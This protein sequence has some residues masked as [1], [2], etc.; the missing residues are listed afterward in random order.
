MKK[1]SKKK[2][3]RGNAEYKKKTVK[4]KLSDI[5]PSTK[6]ECHMLDLSM[7]DIFDELNWFIETLIGKISKKSIDYQNK[8][9][10]EYFENIINEF[11][12][13][14]KFIES[15]KEN[16]KIIKYL[17]KDIKKIFKN[18][19]IFLAL[20]EIEKKKLNVSLHEL[21]R[22]QPNNICNMDSN[23]HGVYDKLNISFD[24]HNLEKEEG[25]VI[26]KPIFSRKTHIDS[27]GKRTMTLDPPE[28]LEFFK[29]S[30]Y[31]FV[32]KMKRY[33]SKI[34]DKNKNTYIVNDMD[35]LKYL[36]NG[37]IFEIFDKFENEFLKYTSNHIHSEEELHFDFFDIIFKISSE[38][39]EYH[40]DKLLEEND[41][42][43][44]FS[45]KKIN[46]TFLNFIRKCINEK[47]EFV[48]SRLIEHWKD[49]VEK[50]N[51]LKYDKRRLRKN[52][53]KSYLTKYLNQNNFI[54]PFEKKDFYKKG[55]P[56]EKKDKNGDIV[57][58]EN[59]DKI[60]VY[61]WKL[62]DFKFK[63]INREVLNDAKIEIERL[64]NKVESESNEIELNKILE[65]PNIN[66]INRL[67][68]EIKRTFGIENEATGKLLRE[69]LKDLI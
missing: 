18:I 45:N 30:F 7:E 41:S 22:N 21:F 55:D 17:K 10:I 8:D 6:E 16:Q 27:W 56:V 43:N 44:K 35:I 29:P 12:E 1:N 14:D 3:H 62:R 42:S 49:I 67:C 39:E 25:K 47:G 13:S 68:S 46:R 20:K 24:I 65:Q 58:D 52:K 51:K 33:D 48:K 66:I 5:I 26:L 40:F 69:E 60:Y 15:E 54:N 34:L 4:N 50:W 32:C 37:E 63:F 2:H 28:S 59:G 53:I 11:I 19:D 64:D 38:S 23:F 9:K 36:A 57:Y 61:N 31:A